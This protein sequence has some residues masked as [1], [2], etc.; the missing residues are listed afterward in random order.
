MTTATNESTKFDAI[1]RA[2]RDQ[3]AESGIVGLR[4][5][6]VARRAECSVSLIYR[7]FTSRDGLIAHVLTE[8]YSRNIDR[9]REIVYEVEHG[10]GPVDVE[11]IIDSLPLPSSDYTRKVRW[12][13]VQA[14]AASVDNTILRDRLAFLARE[15]QALSERLINCVARRNAVTITFDVPAFTQLTMSFAFMLIH[16]EFMDSSEQLDD[17]RMRA[18]YRDLIGRYLS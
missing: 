14:L 4:V 6:E 8:D 18:M 7:H 5:Q 9:W 17:E 12:T 2:A 13:R 15:F 16:N 11:R 10:T 3:I 1:V